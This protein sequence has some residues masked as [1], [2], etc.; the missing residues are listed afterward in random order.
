MFECDQA[1]VGK[2]I[3]KRIWNQRIGYI[4]L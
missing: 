2:S 1:S 3:L 4:I